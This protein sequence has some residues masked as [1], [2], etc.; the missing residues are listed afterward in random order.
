MRNLGF[1]AAACS[2]LVFLSFAGS[3]AQAAR[4]KMPSIRA[5]N[6][7]AIHVPKMP[8]VVVPVRKVV[9]PP[10]IPTA[11]SFLASKRH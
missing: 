8:A 1:T 5:I 11:A 6:I 9:V 10:T 4:F 2:A 3:P 7:G